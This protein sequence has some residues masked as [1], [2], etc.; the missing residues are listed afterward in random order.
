MDNLDF[1]INYLLEEKKIKE[2]IPSSIQDKI[3]LWRALVNERMPE[4]ISL[5]YLEKEDEF[6]S[7][8]FSKL[9]IIDVHDIETITNSK[10]ALYQGDI[11]KIKI[12]AIVNAASN[13]GLGCFIPGHNCLDNQITTF[14]GVRLRLEDKEEMNKIGNY[15]KAGNAFITKG[16]NLKAK[17]V[18]HT[19]GPIIRDEVLDYQKEELRNCYINSLDLAKKNNIRTIAFP[20]ISTGVFNFPKDLA[21]SIAIN[22]IKEYLKDN[23]SYFDKVVLV[24]Y[25]EK[26]YELYLRQLNNDV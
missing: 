18:I 2:N 6:L 19:V 21:F 5:E 20:S 24:A 13:E 26:D 9:N 25:S 8:Y 7:E 22:T 3:T 16:Y 4:E 14:A 12:D 17:Y 10:L 15:L 11:T 23:N 1:L